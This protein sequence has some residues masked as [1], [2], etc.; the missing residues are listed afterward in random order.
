[1]TNAS[2]E[3]LLNPLVLIQVEPYRLLLIPVPFTW[4]ET[5]SLTTVLL[6]VCLIPLLLEEIHR[7]RPLLS[8]FLY[9]GKGSAHSIL[10][11]LCE[12]AL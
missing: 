11:K 2:L 5:P 9:R 4:F 8:E 3:I 1:M 7:C 10:E 6:P 12:S